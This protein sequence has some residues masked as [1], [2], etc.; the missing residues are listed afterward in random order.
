[1]KYANEIRFY[2]ALK[3]H[4]IGTYYDNKERSVTYDRQCDG[5]Y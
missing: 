2:A 1:M 4:E 3:V 5:L